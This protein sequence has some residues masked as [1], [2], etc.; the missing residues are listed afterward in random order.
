MKSRMLKS[1]KKKSIRKALI[2]MKMY[3]D[4]E[5]RAF[6]ARMEYKWQSICMS[7]Q[8]KCT[9]SE[10]TLKLII[11]SHE[12]SARCF[13]SNNNLL[14]NAYMKSKAQFSCRCLCCY[15]CFCCWCVS[16]EL[17]VASLSSGSKHELHLWWDRLNQPQIIGRYDKLY[18]Q[19]MHGFLCALSQWEC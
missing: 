7:K 10:R 14:I 9:W 18:M 15:Y 16:F 19:R 5:N 4:F 12:Q 1:N 6:D 13:I 3:H 8:H 2:W 17:C 11:T